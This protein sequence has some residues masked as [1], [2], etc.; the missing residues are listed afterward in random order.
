MADIKEITKKLEEGVQ[1]VFD[2]D[3]FKNY[4]T[5]MSKF[6]NYSLNNTLLIY[7][8]RH[9]ASLVAGFR[10]WQNDFERTVKKGEKA[11]WI[12]A[13]IAHK[14][15]RVDKDGNEEE[16]VWNS[17]RPVHVFDVSQ[18]EGKDLPMYNIADLDGDVD[19]YETTMK[20]LEALSPVPV[21]FDTIDGDAHGYF[22][23]SNKEIVI[24]DMMSESQTIKTT[25]HEIAHAMLHANS[26][27][28]SEDKE[29]QAEAVAYVVSQHLGLDTAEYSFGY[30]AGWSGGKDIKMLQKHLEVIRKTADTIIKGLEAA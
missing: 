21:F 11:I 26:D 22:S 14:S 7:S 13:P 23:P 2:S 24:D 5:A 25:I 19:G 8:Q 10:K 20:K 18:T 3:N 9:D 29:I 28:S 16:V 6:H 15:K 27:L 12:L 1:S 4:L 30:I 17:F